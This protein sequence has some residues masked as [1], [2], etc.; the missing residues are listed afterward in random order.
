MIEKGKA[1]EDEEGGEAG[2]VETTLAA[3]TARSSRSKPFIRVKRD[4][5]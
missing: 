3:T 2:G 5:K 1:E 4:I